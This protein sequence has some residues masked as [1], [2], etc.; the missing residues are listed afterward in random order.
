MRD[1]CTMSH[2]GK[3]ELSPRDVPRTERSSNG[4]VSRHRKGNSRFQ[5][6]SD[7]RW[8]SFIF[9]SDQEFD[10]DVNVRRSSF[11]R[12]MLIYCTLLQ[13]ARNREQDTS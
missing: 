9:P 1:T 6:Y 11:G 12:L 2:G 3:K 13:P 7:P 4:G 10:A 5:N 8:F